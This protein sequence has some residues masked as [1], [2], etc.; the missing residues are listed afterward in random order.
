M[1]IASRVIMAA[2]VFFHVPVDIAIIPFR[3]YINAKGDSLMAMPCFLKEKTASLRRASYTAFIVFVFVLA[4]PSCL[5][6]VPVRDQPSTKSFYDK[7][8]LIMT[9]DEARV[10]KSL[11][12]E[13]SRAEF[14]REFWAIRDPDPATPENEAKVEFEK[15]ARYAALWFGTNN[16]YKGRDPGGTL[17]YTGGWS[18]ERGRVYILLGK[19]DTI[20]FYDGLHETT[21]HDGSRTPLG[22]EKYILEEWIYDKV[23]TF[24]VFRRMAPGLG[25]DRSQRDALDPIFDPVLGYE[26]G[27]SRAREPAGGP[28]TW[29]LDSFQA[30]LIDLLEWAKLNWLTSEVQGDVTP[31]FKFSAALGPLGLQ[32]AVPVERVSVDDKFRVSLD[33]Q[34]N[35]YRDNVKI[36]EIRLTKELQETRENLFE[37]RELRFGIPYAP[38]QKGGYL[39]DIIIKDKLART[40]S[41]YRVLIQQSF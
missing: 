26:Y 25:G 37:N 6:R 32:I 29:Y 36:D 18:D 2:R 34:V 39:F 21:S 41:K 4:G 17:K 14:M 38:A 33:V 27:T 9:G 20:I 15:R 12:D 7:A 3:L 40:G 1:K 13:T 23:Q 24:A 35:V 22:S 16:P 8:R 11:P 19:P 5:S 10:F 28:G 30:N 31:W